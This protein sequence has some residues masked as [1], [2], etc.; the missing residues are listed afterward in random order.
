MT[1]KKK[2]GQTY[3]RW[4]ERMA[5]LSAERKYLQTRLAAVNQLLSLVQEARQELPKNEKQRHV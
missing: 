3:G 2:N 5:D 1:K 4:T